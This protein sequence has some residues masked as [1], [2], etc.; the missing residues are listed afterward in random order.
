VTGRAELM[1]SPHP[2]GL[3]GTFG[4]NPVS[5]AAASAVLD[6]LAEPGFRERAEA[7]AELVRGRLEKLA[8][9]HES[10]GEVRGLGSMLAIE[11]AEKSGEVTKAITT[12]ARENGLVLLSCGLYGNVIRLLPPVTASDEELDRGLTILENAVSA[13]S[14]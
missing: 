2:G 13:A 10:I 5:C 6:A 8:A 9:R 12:H 14:P 11:F 3:G 4:G 7:V 1:D